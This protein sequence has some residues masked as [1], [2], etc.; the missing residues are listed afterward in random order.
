[1]AC[2]ESALMATET[3]HHVVA[4]EE[5]SAPNVE[6]LE[7]L[8]TCW[9]CWNCWQLLEL[10]ELLE[11]PPQA[12]P[13]QLLSSEGSI[14]EKLKNQNKYTGLKTRRPEKENLL[15]LASFFKMD[16]RRRPFN[17]KP[18]VFINNPRTRPEAQGSFG[19]ERT[20]QECQKS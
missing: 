13:P 5:S 19:G 16:F 1:M 6:L 3:L 2:E 9:N 18:L 14:G 17:H 10:L 4:C 20:F 8:A 12:V 15:F 11:L 7:L